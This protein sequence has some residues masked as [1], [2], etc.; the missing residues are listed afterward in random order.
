MDALQFE[1]NQE[2]EELMT[3]STNFESSILDGSVADAE[4]E[5]IEIDVGEDVT[6]EF[7][8][9]HQQFTNKSSPGFF[10]N[11]SKLGI[12]RF[13]SGDI[14]PAALRSEIQSVVAYEE[15]K[16]M[17]SKAEG[18][19]REIDVVSVFAGV[20][21]LSKEDKT[22]REVWCFPRGIGYCI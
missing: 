21:S 5:N 7:H 2:F 14:L 18:R 22:L 4:E 1:E 17:F 8:N 10:Q 16:A 13:R 12:W 9:F 19:F 15:N 6:E 20:P 11:D 3:E